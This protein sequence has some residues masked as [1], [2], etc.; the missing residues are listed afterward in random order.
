MD[1]GGVASLVTCVDVN[2]LAKELLDDG[3]EGGVLRQGKAAEC[4]VDGLKTPVERARVEAVWG[5][6]LLN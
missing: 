3:D 6:N 4:Q 2:A 5:V 1:E